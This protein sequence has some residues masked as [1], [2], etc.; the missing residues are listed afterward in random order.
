MSPFA[1]RPSSLGRVAATLLLAGWLSACGD[2]LEPEPGPQEPVDETP[3]EPDSTRPENG[4]H[5]RH[6]DNGDGSFTTTVD[7][8]SKTE[9]IG[10]DLDAGR[11]V[12]AATDA[13]WD[14]SFQR[15]GIRSR[16]GVNGTGG[17]EVAVLGDKTFAQVSQAP[18]TGYTTDAADG[19]DMGE[20]PDTVFQAGEGWYAYD[21]ATHKLSPRAR[22]YVVRTDSRAYFK[23]E[24]LAYYDDAGTPAMLKL[25][26]A[27]VQG[28]VSGGSL[29]ASVSSSR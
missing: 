20:D 28:P 27:K 16:G 10:L 15:F 3:N 14:L 19:A 7:A 21:P 13:V 11:Q 8:T 9:W 26:W 12:S 24:M 4:T 1:F 5:V 17:V 29:D 6:V 18:A 23:V 2:D 22:V 25:R